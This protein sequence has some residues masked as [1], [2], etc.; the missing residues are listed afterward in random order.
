MTRA[1][2]EECDVA[3]VGAGPAGIA[4]ASR[5]AE[6]GAR[7]VVIDSG[8]RPGGQIW[9]HLDSSTLPATARVW[10]ARLRR[11]GARVLLRSTVVD[12]DITRGLRIVDP[13][14]AIHIVASRIVVAT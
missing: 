3:V 1:R 6:D 2:A 11:S 13:D 8:L 14:G 7:V 5:A 10:L 9:R 12:G 4:A